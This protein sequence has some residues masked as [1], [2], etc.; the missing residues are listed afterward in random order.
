MLLAIPFAYGIMLT[1]WGS[2]SSGSAA[3]GAAFVKG[4]VSGLLFVL[5]MLLFP[6]VESALRPGIGTYLIRVAEDLGVPVFGGL[7]LF[8]L[9]HRSGARLGGATKVLSIS[10]FLSGAF[11]VVALL[12]ALVRAPF[13]SVYELY[14]LPLLRVSVILIVAFLFGLID[15]ETLWFRYLYM[16]AVVA[17]PVAAGSA[18][19]LALFNYPLPAVVVT[20]VFALG[21]AGLVIADRHS[22]VIARGYAR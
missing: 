10:S 6:D 18:G 11:T 4:A 8:R 3:T 13:F 21:A 1:L 5:L 16:V 9:I 7:L 19:Y 20:V 22:S 15:G 17:A 14:L 12:D 2:R